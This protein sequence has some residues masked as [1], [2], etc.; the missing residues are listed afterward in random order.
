MGI[1]GVAL[2]L[3]AWGSLLR[4]HWQDWRQAHRSR[5][6][7]QAKWHMAATLSI[8]TVLMSSVTDNTLHYAFVLL[9]V[10]IIVAAAMWVN[11]VCIFWMRALPVA[12]DIEGMPPRQVEL[13]TKWQQA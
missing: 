11:G 7:L 1:I 6:A 4:Q 12:Q 5:N 3:L 10:F 2:L 8:T 13:N 9:P